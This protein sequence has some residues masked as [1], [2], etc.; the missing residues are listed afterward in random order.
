V[1]RKQR[2]FAEAHEQITPWEIE[3]YLQL[4]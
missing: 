4:Y 3:R 1:A 2:E